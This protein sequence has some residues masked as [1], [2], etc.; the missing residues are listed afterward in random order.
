MEIKDD[1]YKIMRKKAIEFVRNH[2]KLYGFFELHCLIDV[3]KSMD[4][5]DL[6]IVELAREVLDELGFVPSEY[7]IYEAF[8]NIVNSVHGIENKNIVE[9][10]GG[11]FPRLAKRISLKQKNGSITV[12]DPNLHT[13]C[14]SERFKLKRK[15]ANSYTDV[16]NC[17]LIIGLMPCKG[18]ETL[19]DLALKNEKD[20]VL[21]LCEGGPHGDEFDFFE[22]EEEWRNYIIDKARS[23]VETHGM[24]KLKVKL[25]DQFSNK[26]PIIYNER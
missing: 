18:A 5:P 4:V 14:D 2:N 26:Y 23:G 12:Y 22:D 8:S 24:G 1:E 20:F 21:W 19:L 9:I 7:N 13:E 16:N 15:R 6:Y 25:M 3:F 17:D 11:R 10:G